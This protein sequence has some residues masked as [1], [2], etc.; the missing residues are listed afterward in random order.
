MMSPKYFYFN[1]R[2]QLM[3]VFEYNSSLFL[4]VHVQAALF[5]SLDSKY[6]PKRLSIHCLCGNKVKYGKRAQGRKS[7]SFSKKSSSTHSFIFSLFFSIP[8]FSCCRTLCLVWTRKQFAFPLF[9]GLLFSLCIPLS[10]CFRF[11]VSMDLLF[12]ARKEYERRTQNSFF[13][14][15]FSHSIFDRIKHTVSNK[16]KP[17]KELKS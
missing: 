11:P 12:Q 6:C 2:C 13:T 9:L 8:L 17:K 5:H 10:L 7:Q 16:K 14:S 3:C 15:L 1:K 4:S